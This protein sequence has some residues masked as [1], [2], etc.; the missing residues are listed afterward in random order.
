MFPVIE[1]GIELILDEKLAERE[2]QKKIKE[3]AAALQ[4]IT[5]GLK[6]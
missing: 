3:A 4:K 2:Q 1:T 5:E 6:K